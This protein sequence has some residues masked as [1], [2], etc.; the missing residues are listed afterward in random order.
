QVESTTPARDRILA[1][2]GDL[3]DEASVVFQDFAA[4]PKIDFRFTDVASFGGRRFRWDPQDNNR[5]LIA[6]GHPTVSRV[7]GPKQTRDGG[8]S[9]PG[10]SFPQTRAILAELIADAFVFRKLQDAAPML[11]IETGNLV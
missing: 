2:I 6:A 10:Q 11:G 5:V 9:W 7:L 3:A 1:Q 4:R 8:E